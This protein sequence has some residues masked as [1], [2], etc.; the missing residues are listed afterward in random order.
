[1]YNVHISPLQNNIHTMYTRM[2][3]YDDWC[4]VSSA[5]QSTLS[6]F[7]LTGNPEGIP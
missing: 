2:C 5:V 7:V 3:L 1:M 4:G 6:C